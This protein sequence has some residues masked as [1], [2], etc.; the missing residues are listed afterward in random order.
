MQ[1]PRARDVEDN[2]QTFAGLDLLPNEL[3]ADIVRRVGGADP[4]DAA[5]LCGL[6]SRLYAWCQ[7]PLFDPA[8]LPPTIQRNLDAPPIDRQGPRKVSIAEAVRA[9]TRRDGMRRCVLYALYSL[10]AYLS[11]EG[12]GAPNVPL[13]PFDPNKTDSDWAALL[14][15]LLADDR[16]GP[17]SS[18]YIVSPG[19]GIVLGG[20]V[21]RIYNRLVARPPSLQSYDAVNR[22]LSRVLVRAVVD[23]GSEAHAP[24]AC[25]F[26]DIQRAFYDHNDLPNGHFVTSSDSA[27]ALNVGMLGHLWY[28]W[29]DGTQTFESALDGEPVYVYDTGTVH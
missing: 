27:T 3:L 2:N 17:F 10:Y 21:T 20:Q 6:N 9:R 1:A 22:L 25:A 15:P 23:T 13:L 29:A 7:R 28:P 11:R 5:G 8:L 4:S 18:V 14:F 24:S 19:M 26:V 12:L 16:E